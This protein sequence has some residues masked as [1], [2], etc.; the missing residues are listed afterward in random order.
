MAMDA[1]KRGAGGRG[2]ARNA[3]RRGKGTLRARSRPRLMSKHA[4]LPPRETSW[5]DLVRRIQKKLAKR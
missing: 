3:A 5:R 4:T 1:G 2:R